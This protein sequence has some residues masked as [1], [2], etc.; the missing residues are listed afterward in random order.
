MLKVPN[1]KR[2]SF[3]VGSQHNVLEQWLQVTLRLL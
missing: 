2:R 1:I 3:L